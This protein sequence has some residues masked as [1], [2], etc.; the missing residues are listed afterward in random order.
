MTEHFTETNSLIISHPNALNNEYNIHILCVVRPTGK[1]RIVISYLL[2]NNNGRSEH[3][4][5]RSSDDCKESRQRSKS[6][7]GINLGSD[8]LNSE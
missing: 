8:T 4:I 3:N 5:L 6:P 1:L 7:Q 2:Q